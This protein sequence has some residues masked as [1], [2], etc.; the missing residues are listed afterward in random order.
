MHIQFEVSTSTWQGP[1][2]KEMIAPKN[3]LTLTL[4]DAVLDV[5]ISTDQEIVMEYAISTTE[6]VAFP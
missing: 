3:Y 2:Q 4:I 1:N 5:M 6:Q